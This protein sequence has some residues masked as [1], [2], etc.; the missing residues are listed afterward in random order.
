M[1]NLAH[2][3]PL[4]TVLALLLVLIVALPAT[5]QEEEPEVVLH[6]PCTDTGEAAVITPEE[7]FAGVVETPVGA[8][9]EGRAPAGTYVVDLAGLPEGTRRTVT[10]TL[11]FDGPLS[12][13]DL[14]VNG[15][16]LL[17][18]DNPEYYT[19]SST[20]CRTITV[21]TEVFLGIPTDVLELKATVASK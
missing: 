17:S 6:E 13:Y 9:G 19:L 11:S 10:F 2:M 4:R 7:G 15:D 1:P 14:V 8:L 5:A 12:D 18:T 21:E 16:N 20:H 3:T